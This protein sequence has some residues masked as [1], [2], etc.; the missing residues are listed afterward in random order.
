MD[1]EHAFSPPATQQAIDPAMEAA[2]RS[3]RVRL[4]ELKRRKQ[5]SLSN[6][7]NGYN[8]GKE[9]AADI[10]FDDD[11][12]DDDEAR[13][14]TWST[15]KLIRSFRVKGIKVTIDYNQLKDTIEKGR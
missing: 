13:I 12:D 6:G 14:K 15:A 8:K 7:V 9:S 2:S 5:A 11:D 1:A 4:E 3:R 10:A